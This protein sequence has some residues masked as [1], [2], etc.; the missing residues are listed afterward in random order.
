MKRILEVGRNCW[1][2]AESQHS[3]V[4]IDGR[5]YFRTFVEVARRARRFLLLC[6]WQFDSEVRL[7][8]GADARGRG[9]VR[10]LP[11]LDGLC[12]DNPDLRVYLLAWDYSLLFSLEREWLQEQVFNW[13]SG[14]RVQFRFDKHPALGASHHQKF[15]VADGQ[16]ALLG[17]GDICDHRWDDRRHLPAHPERTDCD[18][19]AY[20]PYHE[21][22]TLQVGPVA[23]RLTQIFSE[24][25]EAVEGAPPVLVTPASTAASTTATDRD[26]CFVLPARAVALSRTLSAP[27]APG[28]RE[29]EEIR[30]LLVD[31]I[32]AARELIYLENQ[33]FSAVAVADAL[34]ERLERPSPRLE[35]VIVLPDRPRS[36]TAEVALGIAQEKLLAS[37]QAEARAHGHRLGVYYPA[38]PTGTGP[39]T[40]VYV[41]SKLLLVDDRFLT[42]GSANTTNRSMGLDTELNV[43]WEYP[44]CGGLELRDALQDLRVDLLAEHTGLAAEEHAAALGR[45]SGLI[46]VLDRVCDDPRG[47]LQRHP[48]EAVPSPGSSP[49]A[50]QLDPERPLLDTALEELLDVAP[51][52]LFA[53]GISALRR[54][55]RGRRPRA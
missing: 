2:V 34:R 41:H 51:D 35:V 16:V 37:L 24:R 14:R 5:A 40:P 33:Y 45:T 21:V 19:D 27:V 39:P 54:W 53:R 13:G 17:S 44:A 1:T 3:G 18:D 55:L 49:E 30:H 48:L 11:F 20:G 23:A 10:L 9:E 15:V 12:R 50:F 36:V 29:V 6:G 25:W 42:V 52:G 26:D 7:L 38:T 31:A 22:Y 32:S 47:R 28:G 43:A 8:R 46:E 4:I